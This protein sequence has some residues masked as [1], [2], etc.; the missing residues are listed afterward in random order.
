MSLIIT[1]YT[2]L[3]SLMIYVVKPLLQ[4]S[5]YAVA[6]SFVL[7]FCLIISGFGGSILFYV[8]V[9]IYIYSLF[10]YQPKKNLTVD[11]I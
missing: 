11:N 3:E 1:F 4:I 7:T 2:A 6:L 5:I 8:L 9:G 10:T